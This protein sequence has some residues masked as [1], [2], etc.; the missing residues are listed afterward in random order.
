MKLLSLALLLASALSA[1]PQLFYSKYFKGSVPE[2]VEIRVERDGQVIYQEA[3]DDDNPIKLQLD[4]EA[5]NQM[6][7]LA[8]KLDRF[9]HPLES[10]LKIAN[11][12]TK[13]FRFTDGDEHHE[14]QFNYSQDLDAQ[15]LLD[16]FE[17]ITETER[18]FADLDRTAHFEKLGVND[19]LI[20]IEA[21]WDRNRLAAPEQFLPLLD[22]IAKNDSYLHI[23]QERA[24][25]LAE[26]IRSPKPQEKPQ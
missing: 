26:A 2:Y 11:L 20:Q 8:Q 24:A 14:I 9:Q 21:S 10:G 7:S 17:R 12:G 19:V 6:F 4:H 13:T 15:A 3:K 23:S 25:A 1:A 16:L 22:R 5:A 18:E